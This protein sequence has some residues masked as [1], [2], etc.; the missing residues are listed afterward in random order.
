MPLPTSLPLGWPSDRPLAISVSVMLEG[1]TDDSAPGIGPMGNPLKA[2]VLDL[3]A[4]SWA[5]YGP[6][7]GAWRLLDILNRL[8]IRAVFYVS[9]I[10]AERHADLI[11]A[12]VEARHVV[13]AHGWAQNIIPAYQNASEE[14]ADLARCLTVLDT[15]TGYRPHGWLSP[16]CTPSSR[17]SEL[18]AGAGFEW[19]ADFFDSDLPYRHKMSAGSITAVPFTM[20]VNDM[21]LYVRYGSE[22][23]AFTATLERIVTNWPRLGRP[24]ACLDVTV[25]AHVFGR[26]FGA[27][28]FMNALELVRRHSDLAW[29][30]DHAALADLFGKT[31]PDAH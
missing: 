4:R 2:G 12:I 13:A 27:I 19:H 17:T 30:T 14:E 1:W 7:V 20:E 29:L 9:G 22:P 25:H 21:P 8:G 10:V 31:D 28:E 23:Q 6:K 11:R 26:P 5:D 18:L 16:R 3:Q 15:A 24:A